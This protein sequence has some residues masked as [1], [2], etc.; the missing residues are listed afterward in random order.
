MFAHGA[1]ARAHASL[2]G[3]GDAEFTSR[4]LPLVAAR[5]RS[6]TPIAACT[7]HRRSPKIIAAP[8]TSSPPQ[9]P[10]PSPPAPPPQGLPAPASEPQSVH[11]SPFELPTGSDSGIVTLKNAVAMAAF[12]AAFI[13]AHV[14]A[15]V[16]ARRAGS[17][18]QEHIPLARAARVCRIAAGRANRAQSSCRAPG[19][20]SA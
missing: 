12:A 3:R 1:V 13:T 5:C 14:A 7:I 15:F 11:S 20:G 2:Q 8:H 6:P 4:S 17:Y 9:P 16:A 18:G 10:Q 19:A